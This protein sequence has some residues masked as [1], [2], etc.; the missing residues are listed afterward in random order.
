ML[1]L[2]LDWSTLPLIC[3]LYRWVL[4]KEVSSTIFKV[5]GMTRPGIEPKSLGPLVNTLPTRPM[6][7][8]DT[9]NNFY[10]KFFSKT[11]NTQ[12]ML[13]LVKQYAIKTD[14]I[15]IIYGKNLQQWNPVTKNTIATLLQSKIKL[16]EY[17]K[18]IYLHT[19]IFII[20]VSR[21]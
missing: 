12:I 19:D 20:R 10:K 16:H 18:D 21:L 5:F 13:F 9:P 7:Q 1:L 11:K 17:F 14:F 4:S 8:S 2:S 3:T 6:S 15:S